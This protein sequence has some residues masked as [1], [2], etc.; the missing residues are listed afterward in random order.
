MRYCGTALKRY[1]IQYSS[2]INNGI[3]FLHIVLPLCQTHP[4]FVVGPA[5]KG[6][7]IVLESVMRLVL[8]CDQVASRS[9][10]ACAETETLH[11]GLHER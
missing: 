3:Q 2:I 8:R 7:E 6:E 1:G 4:H 11:L 5:C 10:W 9:Q